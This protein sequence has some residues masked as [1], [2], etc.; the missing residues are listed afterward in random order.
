VST[1]GP[2]D[3]VRRT[4][5]RWGTGGGAIGLVVGV[6]G[7]LLVGGNLT[8]LGVGAVG[9]VAAVAGV[10][11]TATGQVMAHSDR[12]STRGKDELDRLERAES[13][14]RARAEARQQVRDAAAAVVLEAFR[15]VASLTTSSCS[16]TRS[17]FSSPTGADSPSAVSTWRSSR[18]WSSRTLA[19][20]RP[21]S[22]VAGG[23]ATWWQTTKPFAIPADQAGGRPLLTRAAVVTFTLEGRR[24]WRTQS[25]NP[26]ELVLGALPDLYEEN[27]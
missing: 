22:L 7:G 24:T 6:I 16:A 10:V 11:L 14:A 27:R 26:P 20:D 5:I 12:R 3:P 21:L 8:V 18:P 4:R 9:A 2:S 23:S 19:G 1:G 17:V 25:G 13:R 15:G